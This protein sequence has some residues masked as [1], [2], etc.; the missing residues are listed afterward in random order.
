MNDDER[1]ALAQIQQTAKDGDITY[2]DDSLTELYDAEI[3]E[4]FEALH[5]LQRGR[6]S[7]RGLWASNQST[8]GMCLDL[9][10]GVPAPSAYE[11]CKKLTEQFAIQITPGSLWADVGAALRNKRQS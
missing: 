2:A 9:S 6:R 8:V 7:K 5:M 1:K 4:V 10:E 11:V 3:Q